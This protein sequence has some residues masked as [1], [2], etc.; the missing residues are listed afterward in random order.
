MCF[1]WLYL[2]P[3]GISLNIVQI[4]NPGEGGTAMSS[5][6]HLAADVL[7]GD[8]LGKL[9]GTAF[10]DMAST[11]SDWGRQVVNLVTDGQPNCEY[12]DDDRYYAR[13]FWFDNPN[14]DPNSAEWAQQFVLGKL[15]TEAALTYFNSIVPLNAGEGDE[16]DAEA[17]GDDTDVPWMRDNVVWPQPGDDTWPPAG[18]GWVREVADFTELAQTFKEKFQLIFNEI[19][20]CAEITGGL[21]R[22]TNPDKNQDCV[23]FVPS[24]VD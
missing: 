13:W 15:D 24:I 5:A 9:V 19:E 8:P 1:S 22:D 20:N 10:E 7:S 4:S 11:H 21:I 18:P 3:I 23:T 16:I 14:P 6:F 17:V 12:L 2:F